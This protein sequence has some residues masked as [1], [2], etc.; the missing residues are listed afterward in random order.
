MPF[1]QPFRQYLL[2]TCGMLDIVLIAGDTDGNKAK[3][4]PQGL[5][6]QGAV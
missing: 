4:P 1:I 5:G 3:M 6:G 2:S